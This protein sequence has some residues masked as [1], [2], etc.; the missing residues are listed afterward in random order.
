MPDHRKRA[1]DTLVFLITRVNAVKAD[2]VA[3]PKNMKIAYSDLARNIYSDEKWYPS[4]ARYVRH[5]LGLIKFAI[6]RANYDR[7][8]PPTPQLQYLVFSKKTGLAREGATFLGDDITPSNQ[9]D[10]IVRSISEY[11]WSDSVIELLRNYIRNGPP[12]LTRKIAEEY[13]RDHKR[14]FVVILPKLLP[15]W[16]NT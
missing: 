14:F 2:R 13:D 7:P 12:A 11:D 6:A 1:E 15:T 10:A 8:I 3:A 9:Q 5:P 4:L 16:R